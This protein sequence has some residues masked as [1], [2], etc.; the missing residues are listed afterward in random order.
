MQIVLSLGAVKYQT[1]NYIR[2]LALAIHF[3]LPVY[4]YAQSPLVFKN[5]TINDG[6]SHNNARGI[7]HDSRGFVWIATLDG[8]NRFDGYSFKEYK[9]KPGDTRSLPTNNIIDVAEDKNGMIWV[10]T[11]GGG[12]CLYDHKTDS[13]RRIPYTDGE[14]DSTMTSSAFIQELF[15]DTF[16]NLWITTQSSGISVTDPDNLHFTHY[17][18][19]PQ[20][21]TSLSNNSTWRMNQGDNGTLW[22]AT[23]GGVNQFDPSTGKFKHFRHDPYDPESLSSD[24]VHFAYF[25]SKKRLWVG[26]GD[27][28]LNMM[29]GESGKFVHFQN[30]PLDPKSIPSTDATAGLE[31]QDGQIWIATRWGVALYNET[32]YNFTTYRHVPFDNKSLSA[33]NIKSIYEDQN[34]IVWLGTYTGGVNIF[35]KSF[36]QVA[37]YYATPDKT[38]LSYNDVS[39]FCELNDSTFLV[40]T[41]GGGLNVFD[42]KA[43][44]FTQYKN[45]PLDRHSLKT[46]VIKSILK[47]REGRALIGLYVGGIDLFDPEKKSFSHLGNKE[48]ENKWSEDV[49]ISCLSQDKE[50]SIW[51]ATWGQGIFKFNPD[52][53]SF[54]QFI[55]NPQD[56][57]SITNNNAWSII[58]D[59]EDNIWI[60]TSNGMLELYDR[61][62]NG[63]IHY[64]LREAGEVAVVVLVL[65]EDSKGRL[66]IGSEGG[67]LKR[68]NKEDGTMITYRKE[69]GLVSEYVGAIEEDRNGNLWLGTNNGIIS[70]DP[71]RT[72]F[73]NYGLNYGLQSLQFN[74]ISSLRL[75]S[76]EMMFG[77]INGFNVFHPDS[78]SIEQNNLPIVFTDFQIFNKRVQIGGKNSP[79]MADIN[80]TESITLSYRQSV[81]SIEYAGLYYPNPEKI[82]YK[83]RLKGFVDESWQDANRERKV[84]YTNLK[85]GKYVFEVNVV[86][87]TEDA[88]RVLHIT[89][90]PPW[91]QTWW[92]R[93]FAFLAAVSILLLFY[94]LRVRRIERTNKK[95]ALE[96]A[97]R[98]GSLRKANEKLSYAYDHIKLKTEALNEIAIIIESDATGRITDVNPQFVTVTGFE[99]EQ[100]V[101]KTYFELKDVLFYNGDQA[102]DFFKIIENPLPM[103][104]AWKGEVHSLSRERQP[105]WFLKNMIPLY[106]KGSFTGYFS[107]SYDITRK[108]KQE[109][110]IIEAKR[111]AEEASEAKENFLSVMSHEIRTPLNS[112]IG[113]SSL[114]LSRSPREDQLEIVKVL[115]NSGDN[116]MYLINNILD[117]NKIRAGK[118]EIEKFSFNIYEQINQLRSTYEPLAAD[119]GVK[120]MLVTTP[121]LPQQLVGD[122]MRLNQVLN[123]LLHN[124]FKFTTTGYIKLAVSSLSS[125]YDTCRLSFTVEDTGIG[126]P[127]E[128]LKTIFDPFHQSEKSISRRFGG[129]GLGLS[130]VKDLVELLK[131][132]ITVTSQ[133]DKG[134]TFK[135]VVPFGLDNNEESIFSDIVETLVPA[136]PSLEGC[137]I[138]Y[139]EDV[140]SNQVLLTNFLGDRNIKCVTVSSGEAALLKT[141]H[142]QFDAILMDLQMPGMNG[143]EAADAIKKQKG[144]KNHDTPIVAFTAENY[145][146]T[147]K[148][149]IMEV[150]MQDLITK[151]FRLEV[152]LEKLAKAR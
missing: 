117:Y 39:A 110:E 120:F 101:G 55:F 57:S 71:E 54:E 65:F 7:I 51:A 69:D 17:Q 150:G 12:V 87:N 23:Q 106:D 144:G 96:V 118:I 70:F 38:S 129:T 63:F 127:E 68:F 43:G 115:K 109:E 2:F 83:Y 16:G 52:L 84:T 58:C 41:D 119:K 56:P 75:S 4:L 59:S 85:P 40:G 151:P 37:H 143:Y 112:V 100:I 122:S 147:L 30:N 73:L 121:N 95:L 31:T 26:T 149:R 139:V 132:T 48:W 138:L 98:T 116:L 142:E 67:G 15:V 88:S 126:I 111:V 99:K 62:N 45:T 64:D 124:A 148:A 66:W 35:D 86:G 76:G 105:V 74:R 140:E 81:F 135:I 128:N 107:F 22:I 53:S 89:V 3:L 152:L 108:K 36:V 20:D 93:A 47:T 133:M 18:H 125:D 146:E 82:K 141:Q 44:T 8:L 113:I 5:F 79:L 77:G 136:A 130:I 24:F 27:K 42:K 11:W 9:A 10:G 102:P 104:K 28:I 137:R 103:G 19:N 6:L 50:G 78:L 92:A 61:K 94:K 34:G 90:T 80:E 46:N 134:S 114:L 32:E 145:S 33:N 14:P 60:G 25:D 13:F 97:E 21:S 123:N 1:M 131:G 29:E 49:R 72:V 91:W